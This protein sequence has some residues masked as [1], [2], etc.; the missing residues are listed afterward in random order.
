MTGAGAGGRADGTAEWYRR[1]AELE[2]RG[3]SAVYEDWGRGV[4]GDERML[5]RIRSLPEQR[6]Q[7]NLVFACSRLL[8]AP[9]GGYPAWRDWTL[10]HW[11]AVAAEALRRRTQTNEPGRCAVLLPA[12]AAIPGPIAL[13]ELGTAAGLCLY[14]DRYAYRYDGG[15]VLGRSSVLL[16]CA[17]TAGAEGSAP[18][19]PPGIAGWPGIAGLPEIVWRAGIDLHPLDVRDGDAMRWLETLVWPEEHD[20]RER[21]RAAAGIVRAEGAAGRPPLLVAGDLVDCLDDVAALAPAEATL[22]IMHTAV[23]P[24]VV[25]AER[26]RLFARIRALAAERGARWIAAEGTPAFTWLFPRAA[27]S[28]TR[29]ALV[30]DGALRG[31]AGAHGEYLELLPDAQLPGAQ[32][33]GA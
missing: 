19:R 20:R 6:R 33:A 12:L 10:A 32:P 21:I 29:F 23:M 14:P 18:R 7:P 8:G 26:E 17:T 2:A 28:S 4:A 25:R 30:V 1:F 22:V 3:R 9:E 16:D 31:F 13:L 15:P 24:Y 5:A 27:R 11:D